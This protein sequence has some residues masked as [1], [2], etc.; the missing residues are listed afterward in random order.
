MSKTDN[1][2][3]IT[4]YLFVDFENLPNFK[5]DKEADEQ[6]KVFVFIANKNLKIP[7]DLALASQKLGDRLIWEIVEGSAKSDLDFQI[8]FAM[9]I[10]HRDTPEGIEFIVYSKEIAFDPLI[11]HLNSIGR[12]SKRVTIDANTPYKRPRR[13]QTNPDSLDQSGD[14][15]PED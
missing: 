13:S 8:C 2:K 1:N 6:S 14:P 11:E 4:K 9:G 12:K 15:A 5:I 10:R 3:E 7:I